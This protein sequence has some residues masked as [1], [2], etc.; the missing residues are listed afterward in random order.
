MVKMKDCQQQ[1]MEG[2]RAASLMTDVD[3]GFNSTS[4]LGKTTQQR[5]GSGSFFLS[6]AGEVALD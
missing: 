5:L 6:I 3:A 4:P 2:K 1:E